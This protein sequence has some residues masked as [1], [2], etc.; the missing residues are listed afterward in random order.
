MLP[1]DGDVVG[2][3]GLGDVSNYLVE[4]S[5]QPFT[6]FTPTVQTIT[7]NCN[8]LTIPFQR[9]RLRAQTNN[10]MNLPH[11]NWYYHSPEMALTGKAISADISVNS[12]ARDMQVRLNLTG[13][14]C[15]LV[16]LLSLPP[17]LLTLFHPFFTS[18]PR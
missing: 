13:Y 10:S 6:V 11:N 8:N 9:F 17:C 7:I 18:F 16:L 4:W 1:A 14:P 15:Y 3:G 2:D 12:T 5:K